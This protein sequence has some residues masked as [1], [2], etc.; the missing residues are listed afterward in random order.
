MVLKYFL[1]YQNLHVE[2]LY[3]SSPIMWCSNLVD[4]PESTETVWMH[5]NS[6][7][8]DV[9][10]MSPFMTSVP[11]PGTGRAAAHHQKTGVCR[12]HSILVCEW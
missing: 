6:A 9:Y 8:S 2:C 1:I 12:S 7:V 11:I 3:L 4:D 5:L 10:F